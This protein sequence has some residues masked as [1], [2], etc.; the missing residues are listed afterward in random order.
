MEAFKPCV[1]VPSVEDLVAPPQ[2]L[3]VLL[4]HRP[5]SI[6]SVAAPWKRQTTADGNR[7]QSLAVGA[8]CSRGRSQQTAADRTSPRTRHTRE[9]AG[10]NPKLTSDEQQGTLQEAL[11]KGGLG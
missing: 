1:D 4:R 9:V 2:G 10:S 3:D 7:R 5:P 8:P 11:D 6:P